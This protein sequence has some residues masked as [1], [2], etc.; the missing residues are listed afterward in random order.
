MTFKT[1]FE[2]DWEAELK[3]WWQNISPVSKKAFLITF[4]MIC[5]I[6]TWHTIT[7]IP[8]NHS[9]SLLKKGIHLNFQYN[10]PNGRFAGGVLQQLTGGHIFPIFNDVVCFAFFALSLIYLANYWHIPKTVFIYTVFSLFIALMP[11]TLPWVYFT[12]HQTYF[13][14]MFL[15]I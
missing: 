6:F 15:M 10:D 1:L 5:F 3:S 7:F 13:I 14:D 8:D 11:Y 4:L 2:L 12:R 9:L